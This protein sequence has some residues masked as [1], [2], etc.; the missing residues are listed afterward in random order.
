[1]A[2]MSFDKLI[3]KYPTEVQALAA[4]A[5][6]FILDTLPK[7]D[8]SLDESGGVVGYGYGSGYKGTICTLILSKS[9]VKLGL[10]G[11]ATLPD[12]DGLLEGSGKVHRYVQLRAPADIRR[13]GVTRLLKAARAAW[14]E[15]AG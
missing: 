5:R 11:G 7:S 1:M 9:G 15:R 8:E 3:G 2:T 4:S 10:V 6:K 12:P 13:P 14:Q